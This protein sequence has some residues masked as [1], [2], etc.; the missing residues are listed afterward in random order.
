MEGGTLHRLRV[1]WW[2][3]KRG[4]GACD[5]KVAKLQKKED[6]KVT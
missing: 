5:A 6:E 2:K 4:G 3:Q 1:K